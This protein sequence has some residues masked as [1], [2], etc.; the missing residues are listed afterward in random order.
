MKHLGLFEGIG[1]FSLAARWMG[2]ETVA[3][4]EINPFCQKVLGHYFPKAVGHS[5]IKTTD[6]RIY[7][8]AI[9]IITGGF[10]CTQTSVSAAIHNSRHGLD[11]K[12][13]SLWFEQLRAMEEVRPSWGIV[14]NVSGVKK[15]E[16]TITGGLEGI[17]YTVTKLE[18][19]ASMFSLPHQRRRVFFIAN[20][21]GKRLQI[22]RPKGSP[23]TEWYE[24]LATSGGDWLQSTPGADR[25]IT[26][27]PGR[28]D[29]M[30]ALGN[31]VSPMMA[32]YV[33][34]QISNAPTGDMV[35]EK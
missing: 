31:S 23:S 19:T 22:T 28:V 2:W 10:P 24:R 14:E 20:A 5:D 15:W 27:L 7:R 26:R 33:F 16:N 21:H 17:G 11:G 34:E 9:D 8:G 1:G 32:K 25:S 12:D 4:C 6:F 3:W 13:S 18:L 29:R 30:R 35:G